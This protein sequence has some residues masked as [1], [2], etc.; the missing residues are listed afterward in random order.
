MNNKNFYTVWAFARLNT[1]RFFRDRLAIF[2]G[3]AFPV[4]FLFVF[5]GIF[6]HDSGV[7][8]K[9]ALISQTD[10]PSSKALIGEINHNKVFK[11]DDKIVSLDGAKEKMNRSQLDATIV[12]P[13]DFGQEVNGRPSGK[14][15]VIFTQ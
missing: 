8:F 2:F 3:I 15:E 4:I 14:V 7:S 1:R 11:V 6:G 5:G 10:N 12:L 9:V 13:K